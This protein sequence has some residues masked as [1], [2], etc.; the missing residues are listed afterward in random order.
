MKCYLPIKQQEWG[1]DKHTHEFNIWK[2]ACWEHELLDPNNG[3]VS[4]TPTQDGE[5]GLGGLDGHGEERA[6][7]LA[8]IWQ[9]DVADP[10]GELLRWRS[11][12]LDSVIPQSCM[13]KDNTENHMS[14][15][16]T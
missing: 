4:D 13:R 1:G 5:K 11:H 12:Q 16:K 2:C 9:A 14:D 3:C 6:R 15:R 7:V 8:L 10:D